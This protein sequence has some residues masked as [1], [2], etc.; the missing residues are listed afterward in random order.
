MD[1]ND[2]QYQFFHR[3]MMILFVRVI[4]VSETYKNSSI[5]P[6]AYASRNMSTVSPNTAQA[7]SVLASTMYRYLRKFESL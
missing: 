5:Q 2:T 6:S 7:V 4:F 3:A 1:D